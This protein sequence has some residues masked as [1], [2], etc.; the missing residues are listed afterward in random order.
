MAVMADLWHHG[1]ITAAL[2]YPVGCL[3]PDWEDFWLF[4][5]PGKSRGNPVRKAGI[6]T[7]KMACSRE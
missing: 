1:F 7:Q 3:L 4:Q 6:I 2:P 5:S